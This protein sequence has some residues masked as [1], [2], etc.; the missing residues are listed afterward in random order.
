MS[1]F[2]STDQDRQP[3]GGG[4]SVPGIGGPG[5][6]ETEPDGR[7]ALRLHAGISAIGALLSAFVTVV[8]LV[9]LGALVPG[10]VFAVVTLAAVGWGGWAL[11]RLRRTRARAR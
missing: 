2:G 9:L 6:A 10:I 3:S 5:S 4:R 7:G 11:W 1:D 8:F